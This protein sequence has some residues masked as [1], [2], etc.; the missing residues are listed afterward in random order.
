MVGTDG[1]AGFSAREV[2]SGAPLRGSL[3]LPLTIPEN[4]RAAPAGAAMPSPETCLILFPAALSVLALALD[5]YMKRFPRRR[6]DVW[7]RPRTSPQR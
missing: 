3:K 7:R 2:M 1:L 6:D 5:L 4:G